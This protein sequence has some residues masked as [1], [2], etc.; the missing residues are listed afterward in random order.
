[1]FTKKELKFAY[2]LAACLL[3]VGAVS[4][5]AYTEEEPEEPLRMM[6]KVVAGNVLFDHQTHTS[7]FGYG[8]SCGD[9]HHTLSEDEYEDAESC[10]ECHDLD[11]GD[12]EVPKRADA[13][14]Q[15]CAGCHE[16]FEAGPFTEDC[17]RCHVK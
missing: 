9:C 3:V 17:S 11:E 8:I 7:E 14:H 12:E 13:F 2:V 10:S 16:D 15:Q 5:A 6:F 4:Y 1:M